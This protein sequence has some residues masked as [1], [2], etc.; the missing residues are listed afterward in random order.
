MSRHA[1]ETVAGCT[2][3]SSVIPLDRCSEA[4]SGILTSALAP[5]NRNAFP[6]LPDSTQVA[7]SIVPSFPCPD[8]SVTD[9]P[10]PSSNP[11]AATSPVAAFAEAGKA[12]I[13]RAL[14]PIAAASRA[15]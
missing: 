10:D 8:A 15:I 7:F 12:T 14:D 11:Y 9:V 3:A 1:L 13:R 5:L 2:Q 6:Y 4:L